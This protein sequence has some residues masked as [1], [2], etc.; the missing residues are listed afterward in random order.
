MKCFTTSLTGLVLL[1]LS[2]TAAQAVTIATVP[3]G[4]L[5]NDPDTRYD[6]PGYGAVDYAYNIGKYEVTAGQAAPPQNQRPSYPDPSSVS[7]YATSV[8]LVLQRNTY[9]SGYT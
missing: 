6:T 8:C 4:N 5:G 3:V 7:H 1:A 2:A 9:F